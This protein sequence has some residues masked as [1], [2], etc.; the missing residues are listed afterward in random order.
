MRA[1]VLLAL[2]IAGCASTHGPNHTP[3]PVASTVD[4]TLWLEH[5]IDVD[6]DKRLTGWSEHPCGAVALATGDRLPDDGNGVKADV[7]AEISAGGAELARWRVPV[8]YQVEDLR[9]EH[10][11][12]R[13]AD[14]ALW[15]DREGRFYER[16]APRDRARTTTCP[17]VARFADSDYV[18]CYDIDDRE[19][20]KARKI[21]AEDVCT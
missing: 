19:L 16:D 12:I 2:L 21:A 15:V 11:G 10:L 14:R 7:V 9:D 20:R 8:D 13:L 6:A 18:V 3:R 4:F 1:A 5:D 17:R